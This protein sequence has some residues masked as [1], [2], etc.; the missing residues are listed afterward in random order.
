MFEA[1]VKYATELSFPK[2]Q[3]FES[4]SQQDYELFFCASGAGNAV[5]DGVSFHFEEA[6]VAIFPPNTTHSEVLTENGKLI[7]VCFSFSDV[8]NK[9]SS[10]VFNTKENPRIEAIFRALIEEL[11]G[12]E[13]Y[14]ETRLNLLASDL[15]IALFRHLAITPMK[16]QVAK[17]TLGYVLNYIETNFAT[18]INW[19]KLA[20]NMG[21]SYEHFRHIFKEVL[22][23]PPK[24]YVLKLKIE[25]TK[26]LLAD[27]K[28]TLKQIA[29]ECNFSSVSHFI[30]TFKAW[31]GSTPNDF[32]RELKEQH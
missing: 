10:G 24:Q 26:E 3:V 30:T 25:K 31:T 11:N 6:H 9:L 20:Q 23:V 28:R 13:D 19:A 27:D 29:K 18:D 17:S 8:P 12:Q 32:R 4:R 15:L 7:S 14:Y 21:Y 2:G 22:G 1:T 16:R 5:I